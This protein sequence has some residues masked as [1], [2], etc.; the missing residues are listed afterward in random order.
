MR[1]SAKIAEN[2]TANMKEQNSRQE[3]QS[4]AWESDQIGAGTWGFVLI[5]RYRLDCMDPYRIVGESGKGAAK[6]LPDPGG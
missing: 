1:E 5:L 4:H 6:L 2:K 3:E